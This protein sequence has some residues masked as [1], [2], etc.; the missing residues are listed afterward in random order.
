M[1]ILEENQNIVQARQALNFFDNKIHTQ[2]KTSQQVKGDCVFCMKS[3]ASVGSTRMLEHL[4]LKCHR[5]PLSVKDKF[6]ALDTKKQK[7]RKEKQEYQTQRVI[8]TSS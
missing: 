7:K 6:R 5:I 8:S 2:G 4:V 1:S 3:V